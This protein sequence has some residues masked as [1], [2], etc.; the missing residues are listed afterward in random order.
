[1]HGSHSLDA[2]GTKDEVKQV[3]GSANWKLVHQWPPRLPVQLQENPIPAR[4]AAAVDVTKTVIGPLPLSPRLAC[5][6]G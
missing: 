6:S 3:Q 2:E 5:Q 4:T 1:M